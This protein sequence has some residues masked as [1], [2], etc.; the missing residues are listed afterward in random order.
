MAVLLVRRLAVLA[1][2]AN[3]L[4][5]SADFLYGASDA[6]RAQLASSASATPRAAH[7]QA[8]ERRSQ[9]PAQLQAKLS[10]WLV[11]PSRAHSSR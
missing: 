8:R 1:A 7:E 9:D 2:Q 4:G 10:C 11:S 6:V 5:C 3:L